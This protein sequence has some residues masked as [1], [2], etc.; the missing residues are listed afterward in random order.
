MKK[1][2]LFLIVLLLIP[3]V[4]AS[5][6]KD[7]PDVFVKN[8]MLEVTIVVGD[9][10]TASDT[11]GAVEIAIALQSEFFS[12][13]QVNAVLASEIDDI[14]NQNLIVVG[15]P[16]ANSVAAEL[17]KYPVDC[18]SLIKPNTGVINIYNL[19]EFSTILVAGSSATDTR[20]ASTVLANY[21]DFDIPSSDSMEIINKQQKKVIIN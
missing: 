15:G 19:G 18:T 3:I 20:R 5:T 21:N 9:L 2:I 16:C 8:N 10:A 4:S 1:L 12:N 14:K 17:M 11:I 6:L 13:S 7:Y